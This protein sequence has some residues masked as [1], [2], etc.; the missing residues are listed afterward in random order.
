MTDKSHCSKENLPSVF[1]IWVPDEL[2]IEERK[3]IRKYI[4]FSSSRVVFI[5]YNSLKTVA[6]SCIWVHPL[7]GLQVPK[8]VEATWVWGDRGLNIQTIMQI[9]Y[10]SCS[11]SSS[12]LSSSLAIQAA[13]SQ[14][15]IYGILP[16]HYQHTRSVIY[17][18]RNIFQAHIKE[19]QRIIHVICN[20]R[21]WFKL[22]R[23]LEVCFGCVCRTGKGHL[24]KRLQGQG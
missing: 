23:V 15:R 3:E 13:C 9:V 2:Q 19:Y 14:L 21:F 6:T 12:R 5:K 1:G 10:L 24:E 17:T 7:S 4:S 18:F 20:T 16:T 22:F 11:N 8:A